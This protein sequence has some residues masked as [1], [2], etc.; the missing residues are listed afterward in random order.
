[1]KAFNIRRPNEALRPA[2]QDKINNQ[3]DIST[4]V[5]QLRNEINKI[6]SDVINAE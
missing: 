3:S 6:I 1:M 4:K 2:I 5:S